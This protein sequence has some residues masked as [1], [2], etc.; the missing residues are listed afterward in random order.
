MPL[1]ADHIERFSGTVLTP[2]SEGYDGARRI[3]NGAID[4]HPG[5]IAQARDATDVAAAVAHA[6]G[7]DMSIAVRAGGHSGA[8]YGVVDDGLVVDVRPM[9]RAE[10]DPDARTVR[11]GAGLT[12]AQ[13]DAATQ[14]HGLAVTGGRISDTGVA[15]LTL[16]SGSGWLERM[17]GLTADNLLGATVVTADG[18]TVHASASEHPDLFWGL[19]GGGGNFG[20]VTEFEL[21]LHPVGPM[22]FGGMLVFEWERAA[23]VLAAYRD[24]M[25]AA[26]D[27]LG[28]CAALQLAPPAPFVPEDLV[29]EPVLNLVVAAFGDLDRAAELAAPLRCL[30][31]VADVVGPMP[32]A[33]LQSMLDEGNPSGMQNYWKAGFLDDLPDQAISDG[34]E[35]AALVPSPTTVVL[36]QPLGG[37]YARVVEH[38]TALSN[39][40]A[41]WVYHALSLW[42]DPADTVVNRAWTAA[43][44]S[45]ME[46]YGHGAAHPNF[47][48]EDAGDRVARFYGDRTHRRLVAVKD[49]WDPHNVF[50]LNQNIRPSH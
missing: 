13:L 20:V 26:P 47:V 6:R 32:Y 18:R 43:F 37:A 50:A 23:E 44:A 27:E 25:R 24:I 11:A 46:P 10:V 8:G 17:H 49:R 41:G 48:S 45:A 38:E 22:V 1:T 12:W 30:E 5:L 14:A 28:G 39:R 21:A 19:R 3:F 31:P 33:A 15:G 36:I 29:G 35:V 4:R 7:H 34:L 9:R 2:G 40:D 16:G 42:P